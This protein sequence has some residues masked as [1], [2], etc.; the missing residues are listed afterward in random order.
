[1]VVGEMWSDCV[2]FSKQILLEEKTIHSSMLPFDIWFTYCEPKT[3]IL[4]N[5]G[6]ALRRLSNGSL[7]KGQN[8]V[9]YMIE[10]CIY[11]LGTGLV[12]LARNGF[13]VK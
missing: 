3:P 11:G 8:K 13:F 7:V 9:G 6:N 4:G 2:L 10:L 1:M 12:T 5:Q